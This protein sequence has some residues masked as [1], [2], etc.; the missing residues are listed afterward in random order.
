[1]SAAGLDPDGKL[2][3]PSFER[4]QDWFLSSG[5]QQA[6]V[7]LSQFIDPQ[8]VEAAVRQLGPYR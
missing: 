3:L 6:R 1:M 4:Q 5:A 2:D 7:D 8:H